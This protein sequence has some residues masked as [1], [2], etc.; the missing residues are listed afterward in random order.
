ML[1]GREKRHSSASTAAAFDA[2]LH[3]GS[4]STSLLVTFCL[5]LVTFCIR[6]YLFYVD[7]VSVLKEIIFFPPWHAQN[8]LDFTMRIMVMTS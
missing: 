2:S 8:D 6:Y 3:K 1:P 4:D 5:F 7:I